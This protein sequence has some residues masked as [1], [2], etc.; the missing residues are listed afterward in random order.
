MDGVGVLL[1]W[2]VLR[3]VEGLKGLSAGGIL[4]LHKFYNVT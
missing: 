4:Y 1:Y 2:A 3:G